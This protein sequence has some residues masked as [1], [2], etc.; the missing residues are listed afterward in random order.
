MAFF[1][2]AGAPSGSFSNFPEVSRD[3][4]EEGNAIYRPGEP[5]AAES[6]IRPRLQWNSRPAPARPA[7]VRA[8]AGLRARGALGVLRAVRGG[9]RPPGRG[10]GP[11]RS[12]QTAVPGTLGAAGAFGIG[13]LGVDGDGRV[14]LQGQGG[15]GSRGSRR[16]VQSSTEVW[17]RDGA[18]REETVGLGARML[19]LGPVQEPEGRRWGLG[20][21]PAGVGGQA[22]R[23]VKGAP[24]SGAEAQRSAGVGGPA[25]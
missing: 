3:G 24:T 5:G 10:W 11:T 15:A 14:S 8:G 6:G 13:S 2:G 21:F 20:P 16:L 17:G 22:S 7:Q 9:G 23:A 4:R 18:G 19:R 1:G 25:S 12:P